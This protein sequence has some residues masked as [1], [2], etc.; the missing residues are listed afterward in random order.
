MKTKKLFN[1]LKSRSK[2]PGTYRFSKATWHRREPLPRLQEKKDLSSRVPQMFSI[3]KK[4]CSMHW[5]KATST[6]V[7]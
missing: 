2:Q 6:R 3:L 4:T 1:L 5:R 7:T